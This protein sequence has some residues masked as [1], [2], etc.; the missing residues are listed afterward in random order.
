[1]GQIQ[2][3]KKKRRGTVRGTNVSKSKN[4]FPICN[5]THLSQAFDV[6]SLK[7]GRGKRERE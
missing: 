3:I 1:M 2:E 4:W 5:N 6:F 7:G